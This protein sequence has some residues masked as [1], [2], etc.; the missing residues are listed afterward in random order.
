MSVKS[1]PWYAWTVLVVATAISIGLN[2]VVSVKAAERA[3]RAERVSQRQADEASREAT[4]SVA[5]TQL[6]I[7]EVAPPTTPAGKEAI[8]AWD[9]MFKLYRCT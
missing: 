2:T 5:R 7:Y 6:A 4:C 8:R 9:G 1:P 3:V